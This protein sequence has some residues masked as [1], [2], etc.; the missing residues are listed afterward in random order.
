MV[1]RSR[2]RNI[3]ALAVWLVTIL[4]V[5]AAIADSGYRTD[6]DYPG[7]GDDWYGRFLPDARRDFPAN[8]VDQASDGDD[9]GRGYEILVASLGYGPP[10]ASTE[11][12]DHEYRFR[13]G[14]RHTDWQ[15]CYVDSNCQ[16]SYFCNGAETCTIDGTCRS[17]S[18]PNCD[19]ADP[20]TDDS[21][22]NDLSQ[23]LHDPLPDPGEVLALF[24]SRAPS[25]T[26]ATLNWSDQPAAESFNVYRAER[27]DMSDMI[28]Y[29]SGVVGTSLEDDGTVGADGLYEYLVNSNGCGGTS[30]LGTD[31]EGVERTPL[32]WCP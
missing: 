5:P 18:P 15:E 16:D 10:L 3:T 19:D 31:G 11:D 2:L 20:C 25:S 28:C 24:L 32:S 22:S 14:D 26:V 29:E 1:V 8:P 4:A 12:P 27:F 7:R 21:C 17:G 13:F 30:T 9:F 6:F 23:C